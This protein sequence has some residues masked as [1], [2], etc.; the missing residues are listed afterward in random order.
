MGKYKYYL[1]DI[2]T[3]NFVLCINSTVF[4]RKDNAHGVANFAIVRGVISVF[5]SQWVGHVVGLI[6]HISTAQIG[7]S[8]VIC[9]FFK[10]LHLA[11]LNKFDRDISLKKLVVFTVSIHLVSILTIGKHVSSCSYEIFIKAKIPY[12]R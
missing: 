7:I 4:V 1:L 9:C 12:C 10:F 2:T 3:W 8:I 11:V 6:E 5:H